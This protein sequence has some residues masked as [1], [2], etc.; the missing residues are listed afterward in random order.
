MPRYEWSDDMGFTIVRLGSFDALWVAFQ[1]TTRGCI[2]AGRQQLQKR[3]LLCF[4]TLF[5]CGATPLLTAGPFP[6]VE[7]SVWVLVAQPNFVM[8]S[9]EVYTI[10]ASHRCLQDAIPASNAHVLGLLQL[11]RRGTNGQMHRT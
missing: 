3:S 11:R 10:S 4:T 2:L 9:V 7:W 8:Q 5:V 1:S 6:R